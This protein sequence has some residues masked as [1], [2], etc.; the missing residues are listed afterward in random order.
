MRLEEYTSEKNVKTGDSRKQNDQNR[1]HK[2][3]GFKQKNKTQKKLPVTVILSDSLVKDIKGW[4]LF[5]K[6]RKVVTKHFS[7]ANTTDMKS[8]LLP[9]KSRNPENIVLHC[10]TNDLKKENSANEISNDIIEVALLRKSDNTNI[11]VSG[12]IP[13]SDKLNAKAI[14]VNRHL[15]NECRKRNI[16]FI[17]NSNINPKYDCNK[18]GLHLNWKVTNK[19]VE[20]FLFALSKFGN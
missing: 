12:I 9:T 13:R 7:G 1:A 2:R 18:S 8:Y 11:L 19:L 6:S 20:N 10:G 16:C 14:E 4:E 15:K 17:S 5:D 3:D